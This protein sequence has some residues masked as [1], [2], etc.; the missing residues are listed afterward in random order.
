MRGSLRLDVGRADHL[1]PLLGFVGN[2]LAE[3]GRR[4]CER[5]ATRLSHPCFD[6]RIGERGVGLLVELV[7]DFSGRARRRAE[8]EP[9][10][11]FIARHELAHRR[12]VRQRLRAGAVVTASARSLPALTCPT[13]TIIG[14]KNTCTWPASKS[15]SA[16][17]PPR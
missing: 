4:A 11:R 9:D 12:N 5:V 14:G 17:P 10:A 16:G 6:L 7:D 1:G 15:V 3:V 8:P 2:E 13:G